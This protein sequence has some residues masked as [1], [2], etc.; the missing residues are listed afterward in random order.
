MGLRV[1]DYGCVE[2]QGQEMPRGFTYQVVAAPME[3]RGRR[4]AASEGQRNEQELGMDPLS[5]FS[6]QLSYLKIPFGARRVADLARRIA[7]DEPTAERKLAALT[8]YLQQHCVYTLDAPATPRGRDAADYFL[9]SSRRGHCDLFATALAVMARAV[10]IP[11]RLVTG[12]A[13]PSP[14]EP[15]GGAAWVFRECDAHAW[16][17]AYVLPWGWVSADA[18]PVGE[19][20]PIPALRRSWLALRF[21]CQDHPFLAATGALVLLTIAAIGATRVWRLRRPSL[22]R[23]GQRGASPRDARGLVMRAYAQLLHLLRRRGRQ[24]RPS[25][26]PLEFLS[27]LENAHPRPGA[28]VQAGPQGRS[29]WLQAA[30]PAI[31]SLTALF[32]AA[33]YGPGPIT[34]EIADQAQQHLAAAREQMRRGTVGPPGPIPGN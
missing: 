6:S 8:A 22:T 7:G 24:R 25:Q 4:P 5:P 14:A 31:S 28:L 32:V 9:F 27:D 15:A 11:T 33:R 21:T 13:F 3:A 20:S 2:A 26:T 12:Y 23:R 18:T 17:E 29:P 1:D 16:V 34:P 10:G 30:L 19:G